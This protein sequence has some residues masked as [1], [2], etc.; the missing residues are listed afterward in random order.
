MPDFWGDLTEWL[1]QQTLADTTLDATLLELTDRLRGGGVPVARINIGRAILHP[2]VGLIDT[3]WQQATGRVDTRYTTR[4]TVRNTVRVDVPF[5][6]L[7][8]GEAPEVLADLTDP[9]ALSRYGLFRALA[10][11]GITGYA[12]FNRHYGLLQPLHMEHAEGFRGAA[13]SFATRRFS[14]FTE[15]DLDGLRRIM[16]PLCTNIRV[17]DE[18]FVS[19]RIAEAYLGRISAR[20]VLA[21]SVERGDGRLIDC[22]I[23]YSDM[24]GSLPLSRQLETQ[25]YLDTVNTYFECL[26]TSI[27]DHGGEVLK[28]IGDGVLAI[29][30]TGAEGRHMRTTCAAAL[31]SAREAV[32]RTAHANKARAEQDLPPIAFGVA[33]HLGSVIWGNVGT[34]ERLDFTATGPEVGIAARLEGLNR[35]LGS[36]I[37]ASAAFADALGQAGEGR[38][39]HTLRGLSE[40]V[41]VYT[42]TAMPG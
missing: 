37:V 16:T 6:T 41:D 27:T 25:D 36:T 32:L 30:P 9:E 28:F 26:A 10:A 38:S 7:M 40:P 8:R 4:E 21:G 39:S 17:A 3:Q 22:A 33:L 31:A 11:D 15:A 34:P 14:G 42:Y 19:T 18:H 23:F 35:K 29:F 20:Q 24:R 12:A 2:V 1:M 5:S 13:V